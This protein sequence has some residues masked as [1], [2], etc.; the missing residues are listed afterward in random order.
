MDLRR[1][2]PVADA[3]PNRHVLG[4]GFGAS[5]PGSTGRSPQWWSIWI[6]WTPSSRPGSGAPM[7]RLLAAYGPKMLELAWTGPRGAYL[8]RQRRAHRAVARDP[9]ANA[10]LGVEHPIILE[11]NPDKAR[12]IARDHLHRFLDQRYNIDKFRRLGYSED[13]IRNGGSNR[14]VDDLVFWGDLESVVENSGVTSAPAPITSASRSW[15]SGPASPRCRNGASWPQL[16]C[17]KPRI[18]SV[19]RLLSQVD[20]ER[21][22]RPRDLRVLLRERRILRTN[23]PGQGRR[24]ALL[25]AT[26]RFEYEPDRQESSTLSYLR[27][28]RPPLRGPSGVPPTST[29][30]AACTN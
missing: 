13:D 10:F 5:R 7:R 19:T 20:L 21:G 8:S 1:E 24:W 3:Y 25:S 30:S 6:S 4:L 11:T 2:S 16:Y 15:A 18:S 29:G 9:G 22:A 28:K 27:P 12:A 26:G 14:I 23:E 17:L